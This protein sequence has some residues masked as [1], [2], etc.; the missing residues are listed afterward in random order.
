MKHVSLGQLC[1]LQDIAPYACVKE[2]NPRKN[3]FRIACRTCPNFSASLHNFDLNI[4]RP[5]TQSCSE[6]TISRAHCC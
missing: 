5:H 6:G 1:L 4:I 3:T 2:S